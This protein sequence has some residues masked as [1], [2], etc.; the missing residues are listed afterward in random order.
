MVLA[1]PSE[2]ALSL[3]CTQISLFFLPPWALLAPLC[4]LPSVRALLPPFE[5]TDAIITP[6]WN[7]PFAGN[8]FFISNLARFEVSSTFCIWGHNLNIVPLD[9]SHSTVSSKSHAHT[10]QQ[11]AGAWSP[12]LES[13][14]SIWMC[15]T[16]AF[17][18]HSQIEL[19]LGSLLGI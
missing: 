15:K 11:N 14:D 3:F 8:R 2:H 10:R 13:N 5:L 6:W 16:H 12:H 9:T 19:S 18:V 7:S 1:I 4:F 17:V